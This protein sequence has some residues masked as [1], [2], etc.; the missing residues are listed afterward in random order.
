MRCVPG[1]PGRLFLAGI[2]YA[3]IVKKAGKPA[4][5]IDLPKINKLIFLL[6]SPETN[7]QNVA[8]H[9]VCYQSERPGNR[10]FLYGPLLA[11]GLLFRIREIADFT[12]VIL[13]FKQQL[14]LW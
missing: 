1:S 3:E 11:C 13:S 8:S 10:P 4:F 12:R 7:F 2:N 6:I 9:K 14:A 5:V